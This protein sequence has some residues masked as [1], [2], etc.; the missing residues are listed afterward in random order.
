MQVVD[1]R[2]AYLVPP[3]PEPLGDGLAELLGDSALRESLAAER[4]LNSYYSTMESKAS[5]AIS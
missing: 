4:K 1:D 5:G 2:T 3:E